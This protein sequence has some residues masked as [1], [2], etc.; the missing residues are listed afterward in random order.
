MFPCLAAVP[1]ES[2]KRL[3]PSDRSMTSWSWSWYCRWMG[4]LHQSLLSECL[5]AS[6][7]VP[8][9]NPLGSC[10]IH[11]ICIFKLLVWNHIPT[12]MAIQNSHTSTSHNGR[13][14]MSSDTRL[15]PTCK[16]AQ[17]GSRAHSCGGFPFKHKCHNLGNLGYSEIPHF[18]TNP[19]SSDRASDHI[20]P[21]IDLQMEKLQLQLRRSL[22]NPLPV[23]RPAE[24]QRTIW[25][26]IPRTGMWNFG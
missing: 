12:T 22:P 21:T 9:P 6:H 25:R 15:T 11:K 4:T 2:K 17:P 19:C 20:L 14:P 3:L 23:W 5:T 24:H 1:F 13:L 16:L 18:E 10:L 8:A 26:A 7:Y